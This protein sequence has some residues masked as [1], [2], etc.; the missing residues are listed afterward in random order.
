MATDRESLAADFHDGPLQAFAVLRMRAHV[1]RRMIEQQSPAILEEARALEQLTEDRLADMR[2][3]LAK[4]RGEEAPALTWPAIL[5]RF[6]RESRMG[7]SH[8]VDPE[9]PSNLL[10]IVQEALHNAHKHSG[11]TEVLV[12]VWREGGEWCASV[13]DNGRGIPADARLWSIE[14]RACR[15][16]GKAW[17]QGTCVEI[18]IP[19]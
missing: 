5:E 1:L 18:R 7:V 6:E 12:H 11:G 10:I 3:F 14:Q 4:L 15:A 17:W 13:K 9:A 16:R 2:A 19:E 8:D